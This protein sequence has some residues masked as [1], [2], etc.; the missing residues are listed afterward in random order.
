M[1]Y[2]N[3]QKGAAKKVYQNVSASGSGTLSDSKHRS[4]TDPCDRY[5]PYWPYQIDNQ[6]P[7][8]MH[9]QPDLGHRIS[10]PMPWA[11]DRSNLIYGWPQM[12]PAFG[13]V[14]FADVVGFTTLSEEI[15]PVEV[16]ALLTGFHREM[17]EQIAAHG[18][19]LYDHVGD[20]AV[21]MWIAADPEVAIL[22]DAISCGLA[23]R[24]AMASWNRDRPAALP[25][26]RI[27]IG[28]HAG[29]LVVGAIGLPGRS[30]LGAFGDTVNVAN[31][32]ER[33]TRTL[34]TDLVVSDDLFR[35][36]AT[37]VP[38]DERLRAFPHVLTA[39]LPGRG[40]PVRVRPALS[41]APSE[42]ERAH[43]DAG[44]TGQHR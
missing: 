21:A 20:G 12:E 6:G 34:G 39:R 22:R 4:W 10:S 36:L 33:M 23:M 30:K 32:I 43:H 7:N 15:A 16:F 3:V 28:I 25:A 2:F 13:V 29:P 1:N 19:T 38:A 41:R 27:G 11:Y 14:L 40:R 44:S 42:H 17:A 37:E 18:A 8:M 9:G 26:T 35:M 5:L 31:R 24:E